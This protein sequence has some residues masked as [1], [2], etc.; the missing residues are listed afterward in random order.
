MLQKVSNAKIAPA[1][2][3]E[4]HI[5]VEPLNMQTAE[6]LLIGTAPLVIC[7]FSYKAQEQMRAAQ[8]AGEGGK[9]RK[10]VAKDF[11]ALYEESHYIS[12]EGWHGVHASSIRNGLI[13]TCRVSPAKMTIA[14]M[15]I[16]AL[17][18]GISRDD[19]VPLIRILD[20]QPRKVEHTVRNATGVADIRVRTMY[21]AWK[22]RV[23]VQFDA[24]QFSPLS[25]ANLMHRFGVQCGI[26][27]GRPFSKS[28]NGMGWG[29]FRIAG[30]SDK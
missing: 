15:S 30:E 21:E 20:A 2:A 23:R 6:F 25:V 13:A 24:D 17:A 26:G 16:F 29:T 10:K 22:M 12:T 14:K 19:Q 27:E 28:S 5:L 3:Q 1:G 18:D 11:D 8:A 4:E 9:K 7:R